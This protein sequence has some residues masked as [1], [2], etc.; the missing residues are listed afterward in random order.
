[1]KKSIYLFGNHT[2]N[3]IKIGMSS[4]PSKR[5]SKLAVGKNKGGKLLFHSEPVFTPGRLE[6]RIQNVL[7]KYALG[8]EWFLYNPKKAEWIIKNMVIEYENI[9]VEQKKQS[10]IHRE[11]RTRLFLTCTEFAEMNNISRTTVSGW[12]NGKKISPRHCK[13]LHDLGISQDAIEMPGER[14]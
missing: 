8:K 11:I 12:G 1:M 14:V 2:D 6:K 4:D 13:M 5:A 10:R 9:P 3:R 7:S